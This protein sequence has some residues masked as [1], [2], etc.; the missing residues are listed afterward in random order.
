MNIRRLLVLQEV[1]AGLFGEIHL[2]GQGQIGPLGL[3]AGISTFHTKRPK[4]YRADSVSLSGN[5]STAS[6]QFGLAAVRTFDPLCRY[7]DILLGLSLLCGQLL[8]CFASAR[9]HR[10]S[11][12][13]HLILSL[14]TLTLYWAW[15]A[16]LRWAKGEAEASK[17][18]SIASHRFP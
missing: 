2:T 16:W 11:L 13:L 14:A 6:R 10:P 17:E 18:V 5:L 8:L 7:A 1:V 12:T 9:H 4:E 3:S 15:A